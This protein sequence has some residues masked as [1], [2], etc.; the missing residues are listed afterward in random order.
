MTYF[1]AFQFVLMPYLCI[2]EPFPCSLLEQSAWPWPASRKQKVSING[3]PKPQ[4]NQDNLQKIQPLRGRQPA[5]DNSEEK[6]SLVLWLKRQTV[7]HQNKTVF[8]FGLGTYAVAF[9]A[10]CAN[11][12]AYT[13][14]KHSEKVSLW[15]HWGWYRIQ[16]SV[17]ET[18]S[19]P[20]RLPAISNR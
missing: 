14:L 12:P 7:T 10:H 19:I 16:M 4:Y 15:N 5:L 18:R 9:L 1:S 17:I 2:F 20:N 13:S 8:S 3:M 11:F 6:A